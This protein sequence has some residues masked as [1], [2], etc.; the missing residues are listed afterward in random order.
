MVFCVAGWQGNDVSEGP[1]AF[2]SIC[3][4]EVGS[5][6]LTNYFTFLQNCT[7]SQLRRLQCAFINDIYGTELCV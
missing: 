1:A 2:I 4:E 6:F 3:L 7:A 5:S